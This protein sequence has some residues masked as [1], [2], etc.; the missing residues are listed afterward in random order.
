M[1]RK[2]QP[3]FKPTDKVHESWFNCFECGYLQLGEGKE[4]FYEL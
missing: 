3:Y 1:N 4:L 2:W